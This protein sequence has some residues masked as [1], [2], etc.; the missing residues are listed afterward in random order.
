LQK[1]K[2]KKVLIIRLSS[3]GDIVLT[4]PVI[5]C[6]KTQ[7][8]ET[9]IHF[10]TK[11]Q[12]LPVIIH[13]PYIDKIITVQ[14]SP[15]EVIDVLK[16]EQYDHLIDLHKNFRSIK[17]RRKLRI[18]STSFSKLNFRKW[19]LVNFKINR[20]P[21][22][23]IVDRYFEAVAG[24]G[25]KN[26]KQGLDYFIA[27]ED[28]VSSHQ[29]P[30]SHRNGFVAFVIG[31]KHK[32]KQ[33]PADK[34]VDLCKLI[35]CP[36]VLLGG[37]EDVKEANA[38]AKHESYKIFVA[39]GKYTLNQSASLI[40]QALVVVSNDTGLMHIAAALRKKLVT[41]WGNTVPQFG[42]YPYMPHHSGNFSI[43]QVEGL[44]CRP[45]S[46]IGYKK[47]PKKHFRCMIDQDIETIGKK[48]NDYLKGNTSLR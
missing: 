10:L 45:C 37:P 44:S 36:V 1:E 35:D 9:A 28:R 2:L 7:T 11:K 17:L 15:D 30:A 13:N 14:K 31:G 43:H 25:I 23:H 19:L 24:F 21:N 4:T 3:I 27:D 20:L 26:D 33:L 46:K 12:F 42:M 47:C 8:P 5:R 38:I 16:L 22:V 48:V 29:L 32:T 18:N 39:C 40:E 34:V 41:I 6:L